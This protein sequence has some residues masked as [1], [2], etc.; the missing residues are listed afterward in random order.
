MEEVGMQIW[1]IRSRNTQ[2]AVQNIHH[3][4]HIHAYGPDY[5]TAHKY[6]NYLYQ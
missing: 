6:D 2:I 1:M 5:T 3:K 4:I